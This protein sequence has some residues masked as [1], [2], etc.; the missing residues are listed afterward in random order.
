MTGRLPS[1]K[2]LISKNI[3]AFVHSTWVPQPVAKGTFWYNLPPLISIL[4]EKFVKSV[5][6]K[7]VCWILS[8]NTY[9][10]SK[11]N[12]YDPFKEAH[13]PSSIDKPVT[14]PTP[15]L[16]IDTKTS[17]ILEDINLGLL[18]RTRRRIIWTWNQC[19]KQLLTSLKGAQFN[20]RS[21]SLLLNFKYPTPV[22]R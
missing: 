11:I 8:N 15:P 1:C 4:L 18:S 6:P 2:A 10:H 20:A 7:P 22:W 14:G 19:T 5:T 13:C 17:V 21:Y 16:D 3:R 12:I 9:P